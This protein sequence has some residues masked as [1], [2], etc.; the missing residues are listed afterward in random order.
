[1]R[2]ALKMSSYYISTNQF[3]WEEIT[4]LKKISVTLLALLMVTAMSVTAMAADFT[5][6]VTNK[7][8][9]ETTTVKNAAGE[10]VAAIIY[11]AN[12]KEIA[13]IPIGALTVTSVSAAQRA[14]T[15]IRNSLTAA[16]NQLTTT[17][18]D[19]I[20]PSIGK[21]VEN[22]SK[23]MTVDDLV[24][25]DLFD[26]S[27]DETA[28]QQLA[29]SGNAIKIRFDL[30]LSSDDLLLVLHNT[31]GTDWELIPDSKVVQNEDGSVTVEF[32]SLSPI[33]FLTDSGRITVLS[34]AP[35][36]PQTGDDF[37]PIVLWGEVGIG[38]I[39]LAAIVLV[40][41]KRPASN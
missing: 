20:V 25:Q 26:V 23:G 31:E 16:Y 7:D 8:A 41:K 35:T 22:Y 17:A 4:M 30:D 2:K 18:L 29:K 24:V 14:D 13:S 15:T 1:M 3:V 19:K 39:L 38:I 10:K 32:D 28:R 6:S 37:S 9:P 5:P 33:A 36:S 27:L 40:I 11:D 12:G 34:N 21:A